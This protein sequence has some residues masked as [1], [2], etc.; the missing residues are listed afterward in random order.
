MFDYV[1]RNSIAPITGRCRWQL[2]APESWLIRCQ[3]WPAA[4]R[5]QILSERASEPEQC[6]GSGGFAG[7]LSTPL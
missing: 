1:K 5:L 6:W 7:R 2:R 4:R 3:S